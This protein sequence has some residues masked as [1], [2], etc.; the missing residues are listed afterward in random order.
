MTKRKYTILPNGLVSLGRND[1]LYNTKYCENTTPEE[2]EK[3]KKTVADIYARAMF[4]QELE[5]RGINPDDVKNYF[6]F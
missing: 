6:A 5:K 3:I 1:I 2:I 4:K